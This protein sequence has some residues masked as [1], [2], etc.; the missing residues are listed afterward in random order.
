MGTVNR[1]FVMKPTFTLRDLLWLMVVLGLSLGWWL[2]H[3]QLKEE[4]FLMSV[5]MVMNLP[6]PEPKPELRVQLL[7]ERNAELEA[8]LARLKQSVAEGPADSS[9]GGE[10][11]P[12]ASAD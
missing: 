2:D 6:G 12:G 4:N 9:A 5:Q 7:E 1:H 8:E 11:E 10:S 3:R